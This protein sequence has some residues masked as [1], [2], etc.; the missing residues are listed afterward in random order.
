[1]TDS[2]SV[3]G[4]VKPEASSPRVGRLVLK[5]FLVFFLL[6]MVVFFGVSLPIYVQYKEGVQEQLLANE[7]I[8]VASAVQMFQKEMYE[9]LHMLDLII[10]TQALR[11]YL[12]EG[13]VEQRIHVEKLFE[14]IATSF[15]RFD[16]IRL[17]DNTGL[18]KIRVNLV[19]GKGQPVAQKDLQSKAQRYYFKAVQNMQPGQIYISTMDLNVENGVIEEPYKPTLRFSTPLKDAQGNQAGVLVINYLAKGML[20]RFR[21]F[22]SR[23][24][25]QQGMLLD[26]QGYWLSNH[27]RSNEWGADLGRPEHG[28]SQ[29]FPNAWQT[30]AANESGVLETKKGV[31]R[32]QSVEPLNFLDNQPAHFRM[33]HYPLITPESYANTN[34]KLVV[35]LPRDV[36]DSHSFLNQPLG[37]TL[38][39]LFIL[40]IA[41][42]ALLGAYLAVHR[43]LRL[44]KEQEI[45]ALLERQA[46]IDAL[47]GIRNRRSFYE[48][49][50]GELKRAFRY[51]EPLTALMVDADYFKKINDTYGHAVG[52]LVLKDLA[53]TMTETLREVDLLG[54]VGG[55]E[56]AVLLLQMTLP[57]ALDV[58]ERLRLEI[59][60]RKVSLPE[61]DSISFTVSIGLAMLSD[62]DKQLGDLFKKADFALYEAKRLGRNR[63][64]NYTEDM[65]RS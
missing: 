4:L 46:S 20:E 1:M 49:G 64:V 62:Q 61:G 50:E 25:D 41:S 8:S 33:E 51:N 34:W 15:H 18:E 10:Q 3:P 24:V 27:E 36:I 14:S 23:R 38:L 56:F 54:R 31:F 21:Q 57:E 29:L 43:Q 45:R 40:M 9:Q 16:Q 39:A 17:L 59:A 7:E 53:K 12:A 35:F 60:E 48:L 58:A 30:V 37:R 5:R 6:L 63:V 44:Q 32:Y 11:E 19:E 28:F 42:L 26:S 13:T 22:M 2:D 65:A 55:E 47:T 52:D